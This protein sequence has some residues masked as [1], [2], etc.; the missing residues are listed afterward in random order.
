MR[1]ETEETVEHERIIHRNT[2]GWQHSYRRERVIF[3]QNKGTTDEVGC[4]KLCADNTQEQWN[5]IVIIV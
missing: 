1:A 2:A 5:R 4:R 3:F